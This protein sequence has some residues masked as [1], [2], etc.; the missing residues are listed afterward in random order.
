MIKGVFG[1]SGSE[2]LTP[3]AVPPN[4]GILSVSLETDDLPG[5]SERV[6]ARG[7]RMIAGPF[8]AE[9]P[10]FGRVLFSTFLGPNGEQ[11][12]FFQRLG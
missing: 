3:S 10:P 2:H 5:I 12:E 4:I 7:A 9:M 11:W 8:E 6:V 1:F